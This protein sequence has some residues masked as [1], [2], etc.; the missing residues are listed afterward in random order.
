MSA[1]RSDWKTRKRDWAIV[2]AILVLAAS[3]SIVTGDAGWIIVIS[4]TYIAVFAFSG[5]RYRSR[6][7]R[8]S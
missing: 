8:S 1:E 3:A 4:A 2:V 6:R 7:R 5:V